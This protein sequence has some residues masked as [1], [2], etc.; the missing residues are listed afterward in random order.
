MSSPWR[1]RNSS[2]LDGSGQ[3]R[4]SEPAARPEGRPGRAE[5]RD[6]VRELVQR[7]LEVG[8]V[9]GSHLVRLRDLR[10]VDRDPVGQAGRRDVGRARTTESGWNST[11]TSSRR[12]EPARHRDEP[13]AAAAMDVDDPA[14]A[15]QVGDELRAVPRAP[16]RRRP[17]CP[18]RS[19][20]RSTRGSGRAGPRSGGR[21][22]RTPASRP[23]R[24]RRPPAWTNCPPRNSG[25]VSSSRTTAT[26]SSTRGSAVVEGHEL[27]GV[28]GPEP[29]VHGRVDAAAGRRQLARPSGRPRPAA[30]SRSNSP[31]STPRY[32]SQ[33]RWNP[34]RLPIR[35]SKRSSRAIVRRIVACA[36]HAATPPR[37]S[38]RCRGALRSGAGGTRVVTGRGGAGSEIRLIRRPGGGAVRAVDA[39]E[40]VR[41]V[42]G[43][44]G[45]LGLQPGLVLGFEVGTTVRGGREADADPLAVVR[46]VVGERVLGGEPGR[47]LGPEVGAGCTAVARPVPSD[48]GRVGILG[49]G[50]R[51]LVARRGPSGRRSAD[52]TSSCWITTAGPAAGWATVDEVPTPWLMARP[53]APTATIPASAAAAASGLTW[54]DWPVVAVLVMADICPYLLAPGPGPVH[55]IDPSVV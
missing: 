31:S 9:V 54:L 45:G 8:Q 27:V 43:D 16:P 25:R 18:G 17:R 6:R 53:T 21:S 23:S 29:G 39:L 11:P 12:R 1:V 32:T 5:R 10:L 47:V 20:A 48:D 42:R 33:V 52:R 40:V 22:G 37:G 7:V 41:E 38:G 14:A 24:A 13:A 3:S 50:D 46:E 51:G 35:S 15:R 28:G 2:R 34:A 44:G 30:R 55:P 4:T 26:S 49:G 36:G 19:A